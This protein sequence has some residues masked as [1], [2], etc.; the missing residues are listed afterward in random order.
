MGYLD[1]F[2]FWGEIIRRNN[3]EA[4]LGGPG[5]ERQGYYP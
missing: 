4:G 3:Y 5:G 2:L 1:I